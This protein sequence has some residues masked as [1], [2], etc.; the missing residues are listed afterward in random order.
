MLTTESKLYST[1]RV[2]IIQ[3][4]Y[5]FL[6]DLVSLS[7]L[8][9]KRGEKTAEFHD[10]SIRLLN[11][12]LQKKDARLALLLTKTLLEI[13]TYAGFYLTGN[14][15]NVRQLCDLIRI[16]FR[17]SKVEI[18]YNV[19]RLVNYYVGN[20]GQTNIRAIFPEKINMMHGNLYECFDQSLTLE[21]L[22]SYLLIDI[23]SAQPLFLDMLSDWDRFE[24]ELSEIDFSKLLWYGFLLDQ[25]Q[26]LKDVLKNYKDLLKSDMWSI[27]FYR[28]IKQNL[29]KNN[30]VD[31]DKIH[32]AIE[33]FNKEKIFS[34]DE[35]KLIVKKIHSSFSAKKNITPKKKEKPVPLNIIK[36]VI[37]LAPHNMPPG[38]NIGD[39]NQK[40]IIELAV[41]ENGSMKNTVKTIRVEA[42]T[43]LKKTAIFA[44]KPMLKKIKKEAGAG[45][46]QVIDDKNAKYRNKLTENKPPKGKWFEGNELFNWPSTE[47]TGTGLAQ[48]TNT[49]GMN[50]ES[51]LRKMGYQITNSTR[52]KRWVVLQ[53]AVPV[54]GLKRVAYTIAGFVRMRKGQKNGKQKF[55]YAI[56]EWEHDLQRLK[57]KYYRKDFTWPMT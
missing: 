51:A 56:S 50:E 52:D 31:H 24:K 53:R 27:R 45:F 20:T 16:Q 39:I 47:V 2:G 23:K 37:R 42:L 7:N 43:D 25:E 35:K 3:G 11:Y 29:T 26:Y 48:D 9:I 44:N 13:Q 41:F 19:M 22:H 17:Y 30:N 21:L 8:G 49:N 54:L 28:Y 32:R 10:L 12:I 5:E 6:T 55:R 14:A 38:I 1:E 40:I 33:R 18:Y 34:T 36:S 57:T 15:T 4:D 46:I